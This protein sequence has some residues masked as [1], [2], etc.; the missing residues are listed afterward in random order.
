LKKSGLFLDLLFGRDH[1]LA[2]DV[3]ELAAFIKK[4]A[5]PLLRQ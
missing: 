5:H 1:R 2:N 4:I 3:T